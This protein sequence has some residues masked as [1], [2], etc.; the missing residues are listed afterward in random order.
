MGLQ[1]QTR[2][3]LRMR[4]IC[5]KLGLCPSTV[6]DFVARGIFIKPFTL[7]PGGRAVGWLEVDVDVDQ[8]I[9]D[10]KE[11]SSLETL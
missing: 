10:R 7:I 2:R 6:H 4:D 3:I 1:A 5:Q 11:A 9:F 8:W